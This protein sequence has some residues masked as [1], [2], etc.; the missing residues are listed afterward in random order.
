MTRLAILADTQHFR[1]NDDLYVLTRVAAQLDQLGSLFECAETCAP[2]HAGPPPP[3]FEP[4]LRGRVAL[5]PLRAS[6]GASLSAKVRLLGRAA[7]WVMPLL[8]T[9]RRAD[10]VHFRCPCNVALVALLVVPSSIPWYA[11]Y[12]GT[13]HAYEDEPWSYRLQ[14]HLLSKR[15]NGIVTVYATPDAITADHIVPFFSPTHT[16]DEMAAE[17]AAAGSKLD[18]LATG[19]APSPF[20]V[21]AVGHLTANKNHATAIK[22]VAAARRAG[23]DVELDIAGGGELLDD[24]KRLVEQLSLSGAVRLHG[25][26]PRDAVGDLLRGGH[27]TVLLSRTEGFP[28]AVMEGMAAGA[29]PILSQFPLAAAMT[30]EGA[31]G[32]VVDGRDADAVA[33]AL[34]A[35]AADPDRLARMARSAQAYAAEHSLDAF[36]LHLANLFQDR[37]PHLFSEVTPSGR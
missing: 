2:L 33:E 12:A 13:W 18:G 36:R 14:R 9:A 28:K 11:L 4:Y 5:R 23:L 17:M 20:R 30:G 7:T 32:V 22:A 3:A 19:K 1:K 21:V 27:A 8:Q 29:P 26:L 37:W 6:G 34:C 31:R 10:F 25:V 15:R 35:L 16:D 24:L